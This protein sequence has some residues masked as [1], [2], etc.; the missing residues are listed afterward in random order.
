M[1]IDILHGDITTRSV[2]AIVNAANSSLLGGGGVDGAIHRAAGPGLLES[3]RELRR[4]ELPAGL[5]VGAAV[6]TP[7]FRLPVRWV[8]H[9]VGPN[10]HAG[11]ID[12]ALLTSCFRGSLAVAAGL[13]ARS[14]AFPAISA[15]IYGWDPRQVAEIAFDAVRSFSSPS[16]VNASSV[17]ASSVDA[18]SLNAAADSPL[19]LVEFV[20]FSEDTTAVFREVFDS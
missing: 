19:E 14:I 8:I 7:G 11:Q 13:G 6:A 18:S 20:L 3:C 5:P 2:D 4:T 17:N 10:R 12:P 15:G 9:T 1:R 16:S